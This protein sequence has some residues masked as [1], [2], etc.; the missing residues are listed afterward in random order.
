MSIAQTLARASST[1][2]AYSKHLAL[3]TGV[4]SAEFA[5]EFSSEF[6]TNYAAKDI[7]YAARRN[8]IRATL[9]AP[10]RRKKI[11]VAA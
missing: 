2:V 6:K 7:E 1:S 8:A 9:P 4:M 5:R 3:S 11:A 10:Q